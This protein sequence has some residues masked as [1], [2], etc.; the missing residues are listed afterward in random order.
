M[1]DINKQTVVLAEIIVF[2]HQVIDRITFDLK[3]INQGWDSE[4]IV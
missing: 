2:D 4:G 1:K 3:H